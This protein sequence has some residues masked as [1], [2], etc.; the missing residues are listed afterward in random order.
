MG[1]KVIESVQAEQAGQFRTLSVI[2][3]SGVRSATDLGRPESV[4]AARRLRAV[5][6][7]RQRVAYD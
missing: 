2:D 7:S 3:A 1:A 5:S 6:R 4:A